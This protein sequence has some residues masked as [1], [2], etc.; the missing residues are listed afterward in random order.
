LVPISSIIGAIGT[1]AGVCSW[2][3]LWVARRRRRKSESIQAGEADMPIIFQRRLSVELMG[4]GTA[5]AEML[6]YFIFHGGD[7]EN[8]SLKLRAIAKI[9]SILLMMSSIDLVSAGV[10]TSK[11]QSHFGQCQR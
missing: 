5:T 3:A 7:D 1:G 2:V 10:I 4:T 8:M 6:V 11:Q 9:S